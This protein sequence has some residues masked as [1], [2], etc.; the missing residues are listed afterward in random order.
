[1]QRFTDYDPFA[2]VY[3]THWGREYHTQSL[4]IMQKLMLRHLPPH[5]KVLDLCCGVGHFTQALVACG[6]D[7]TGLDGSEEMLRYARERVPS[8]PLLVGDAR[9]FQL[10]D[11]FDAVVSTFDSLNHV[12]SLE[13]LCQVFLHVHAVLKNGGYLAFD[14]NRQE[15]Y[16]DCWAQ[17]GVVVE[18]QLVQIARGSYDGDTQT[19]RCD[20]TVFRQEGGWQ[21]S[22]FTMLQK[23]HP[24]PA[25][26][27]L[28]RWCNFSGVAAYDAQKDLGMRGDI[29]FGRSYLI[30]QRVDAVPSA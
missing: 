18:D 4:E 27:D 13:E 29:G 22:D 5:A 30:G 19:A 16:L 20:I 3:N 6:Y 23:L 24:I 15:A 9:S 14:L 2:R 25:V 8:V 26:V 28:L 7:V 11:R 10:P 1:M 12:M 21:R 17:T